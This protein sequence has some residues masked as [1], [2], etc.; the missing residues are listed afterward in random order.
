MT[1][2]PEDAVSDAQNRVFASL[3]VPNY[4]K[5]FFG[6]LIT[7]IG[8]WMQGTAQGWLVLTVLT[9]NSS[10]DLGLVTALQYLFVPILAPWTGAVA[11][12]LPKR[13]ILTA[14]VALTGANALVLAILVNTQHV[15][16]P[17]VYWLALFQ[18]LVT[19]FDQ[20][21][22][23]SFVSEMVDD[24]L[25]ANAVGLNGTSF[26]SARLIGPGIAGLVIGAFGIAPALYVNA[27]GSLGMIWALSTLNV[28]L[29]HPAPVRSG[30]GSII[31]GLRYIKSRHDIVLI[32]V[33]VFLVSTF[34][35]NFQ[36]NNATMA[37]RVFNRG[38]EQYGLLGT[39]LAVG[40]LAG[41]LMAAKREKPRLRVILIGVFGFA[42]FA[43]ALA[44]APNYAWYGILLVPVGYFMLSITN[45]AN[46]T[47]QLSTPPMLRGRVMAVYMAVFT[48][49]APIGAS[50][51]GWIGDAVSPRGAI[52]IGAVV[53]VVTGVGALIY[54]WRNTG[55]RANMEVKWPPK[56]VVY[57]VPSV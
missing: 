2:S 49:G 35:M 8:S 42:A 41:A 7:N 55:V 11:D 34:G 1:Q 9:N 21:A 6:A 57:Y 23:Q 46:S 44:L 50:F 20:P 43:I 15:S 4:R 30:A 40:T 24:H 13:R 27:I 26:N 48:G 18:G 25:L 51:I 56:V 52:M 28:D 5:F 38:A 16:L 32:M 54:L 39:L 22:R 10:F 53:A 17:L 12:R 14:T 3:A 29:L 47:V 19:S 31:E 36:I 33:M 45:T 37:T